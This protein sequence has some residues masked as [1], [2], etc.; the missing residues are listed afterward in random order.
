MSLEWRA[1]ATILGLYRP[2]QGELGPGHGGG[3]FDRT[4]AVMRP[5]PLAVG[6]GTEAGRV[7]NYIRQPHGIPMDFIVTGAA[8]HRAPPTETGRGA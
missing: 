2:I 1:C 4:L 7:E 8:V 6:I 3:H 5:K